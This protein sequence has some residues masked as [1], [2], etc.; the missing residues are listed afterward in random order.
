M[1][2]G[3]GS[4]DGEG[5]IRYAPYLE[6]RHQDLLDSVFGAMGNATTSGLGGVN[7]YGSYDAL[8]LDAGFF[9]VL[10]DGSGGHYE[11]QSFPSLFDMFGKFLGGFDI[12]A[13][14]GDM[15]EE[16]VRGPEI[17]AAVAAHSAVLQDDIDTTVM[18][19]FLAGMRNINA[20]QSSAFVVGKGL[21]SASHVRSVNEFQSKIRLNAIQLTSTL[22]SRHLDWNNE[23]IKVYGEIF[24]LYHATRLDVNRMDMEFEVKDKLWDLGVWDHGR[25]A[26]GAMAGAPA[27]KMGEDSGSGAG[28]IAGGAMSGAAMGASVGGPWGALIGG[29][30]GAAASFL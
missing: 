11:L 19:K 30:V 10:T 20:I 1:S 14:W 8:D 27:A 7:P 29:V 28:G 22:W 23:V 4:S 3:G 13:L 24:K 5:T 2:G 6:E 26:I 12:C 18:P 15:Y 25:A 21:I 9:G 16:V 17:S